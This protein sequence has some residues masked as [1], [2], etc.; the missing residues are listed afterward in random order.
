MPFCYG[1][2][3]VM[4]VTCWPG[5]SSPCRS[6][7]R[8]V[9]L[10]LPMVFILAQFLEHVSGN[11]NVSMNCCSHFYIDFQ[12]CGNRLFIFPVQN[13]R[14]WLPDSDSPSKILSNGGGCIKKGAVLTEIH[15][16]EFSSNFFEIFGTARKSGGER[17]AVAARPDNNRLGRCSNHV[18]T[19]TRI[20]HVAWGT[21]FSPGFAVI[22][23]L[24]FTVL[25]TLPIRFT[26]IS[27]SLTIY[28]E[29][30]GKH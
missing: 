29:R 24:D 26:A 25:H 5:C 22:T 21:L 23:D 20:F 16:V 4:S 1:A 3:F 18:S 19:G 6:V 13:S 2:V 7:S 10:L 12:L 8:G 28:P 30:S 27:F 14:F 17:R 15:H 9:L 11:H